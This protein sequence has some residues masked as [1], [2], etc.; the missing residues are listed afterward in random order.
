MNS[1]TIVL[2]TNIL[3]SGLYS[4]KGAS[5]KILRLIEKG[6][7]KPII[8]TTLLFEYEDILKR[9]QEELILTNEEI[10]IIL[11]NLCSFGYFQK[12]YFLWRPYLK[13][14]KDDHVL[15]VAVASKTRMII[16]HNL[17]DFVGADKFGIKVVSPKKL[18]ETLS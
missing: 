17:K 16:T 9:K 2:D 10:D 6:K 14:P 3:F 13:D 11:N 1:T 4:S 18:L 15:E 12:I 8:S 5:F 7:I